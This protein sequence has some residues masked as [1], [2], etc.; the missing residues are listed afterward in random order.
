VKKCPVCRSCLKQ[1]MLESTGLLYWYC[2]LEKQV[3]K[4]T[5]YNS[6]SQVGFIKEE[7]KLV[8]LSIKSMFGDKIE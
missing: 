3:Y 8:I 6:N 5:L 2:T 1:V 7:D 4:Y